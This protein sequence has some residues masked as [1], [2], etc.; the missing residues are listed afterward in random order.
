MAARSARIILTARDEAT[1][2]LFKVRGALRLVGSAAAAIGLIQFGRAFVQQVQ[3]SVEAAS[4]FE[5]GL[6]GLQLATGKT[7][8]QLAALE[9]QAKQTGRTTIFSARQVAEAQAEL[10]RAGLSV[11]QV[12]AALPGVLNLATAAELEAG[13]AA[14]IAGKTI[15]A[16]ALE[17]EKAAGV[18]DV[19]AKAA[20]V[21][22][23]SIQEV[24]DGLKAAAP[25]AKILG[26]DISEVAAALGILGDRGLEGAQGGAALSTFMAA[27][28][29]QIDKLEGA[30]G[31]E[32]L[33]QRLVDTDGKFIGL[34]ESLR[35]LQDLGI[36]SSK[37]IEIFGLRAGKAA[38]ILLE[39]DDELDS[40]TAKLLDSAGFAAKQA[41]VRLDN[42]AGDTAKLKAALQA[43]QLA[44]GGPLI[45]TLRILTQQGTL[46]AAKLAEMADRGTALGSSID[47][48]TRPFELLIAAGVNAAR[49]LA[50]VYNELQIGIDQAT[51][52]ML[53]GT[54]ELSKTLA[55]LGGVIPGNPLAPIVDDLFALGKATATEAG[56]LTGELELSKQQAAALDIELQRLV[57]DLLKVG[58]AFRKSKAERD[59]LRAEVGGVVPPAGPD[60]PTPELRDPKALDQE[61]DA[62]KRLLEAKLGLESEFSQ[63]AFKLR[64]QLLILEHGQELDAV[65]G[66]LVAERALRAAHV[67]D[68]DALHAESVAARL[69]LERTVE[70]FES[71]RIDALV[72]AETSAADARQVLLDGLL[73]S[74]EQ[75]F[76][77][78]LTRE[79][80]FVVARQA[81]L[82]SA[83]ALELGH[84][85]F[86]EQAEL[87]RAEA[88][89]EQER[90]D[91]ERKTEDKVVLQ[92]LEQAH[93]A[94]LEAIRQEFRDREQAAEENARRKK[95]ADDA[96]SIQRRKALN[97]ATIEAAASLALALFAGSKNLA[98]AEVI[99]NT[100]RAVIAALAFPPGPPATIPMAALVAAKGAVELAVIKSQKAPKFQHGGIIEG[101]RGIDEVFI[102]GTAGEL[103]A[104]T[105]RAEARAILGGR[106][107][108]IPV[109][110]SGGGAGAGGGTVNVTINALDARSIGEYFAVDD[111]RRELLRA[112]GRDARLS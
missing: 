22:G 72:A 99:I 15:E 95:E 1:A 110:A 17:G 60:A 41:A 75:A 88:Q 94:E 84:L 16:F 59:A 71:R 97:Q 73:Q 30:T 105:T 106:A 5:Q 52:S 6:T 9:A 90:A 40:R 104:D 37:A 92:A 85:A 57:L 46:V 29:G 68:V 19:L 103:V 96:R 89:Q 25:L 42:L 50:R 64:Q 12:Y 79:T 51:A 34:A 28:V 77:L 100:A 32:G 78:G 65:A 98:I 91:L 20:Q 43:L 26:A 38:G 49:I 61:L 66:N 86:L 11:E 21:A 27:L 83:L 67:L 2:T 81:A 93:Q 70:D 74:Q 44:G 108:I 76:E 109:A 4:E 87:E 102:R 45:D 36:D 31:L 101:P 56:R 35:V 3:L 58:D 107:A 18:V 63:E 111:N 47:A 23:D 14:E 7:R 13:E 48:L 54:S 62:R 10:A 33:E 80:D 53:R 8:G 112:L 69:A 24:G 82:D 55:A 39:L